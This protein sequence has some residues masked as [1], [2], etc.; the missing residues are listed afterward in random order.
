[1]REF[2]L[3]RYHTVQRL[4]GALRGRQDIAIPSL[5]HGTEPACNRFPVIFKDLKK[6][7]SV[8]G[9]LWKA[10]I[11]T[12]VMYTKPI[13]HLFDLGYKGDE[14][15]HACFAA[16][17]VLTLPVHP[18]VSEGALERMIEVITR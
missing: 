12:S 3:R 18:G 17:H 2:S 10:G 14:F 13:H 9:A 4:A 11:E 16:G 8:Q 5:A 6:R 15:P 7:D 1:M